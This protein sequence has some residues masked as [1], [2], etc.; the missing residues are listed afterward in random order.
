MRVLFDQPTPVPLRALLK[1]Y[2]VTTAAHQGWGKQ[3]GTASCA[4]TS[5]RH[6]PTK[7][8]NRLLPTA[9]CFFPA[10]RIYSTNRIED[11][12]Q[13]ARLQIRRG[14]RGEFTQS[15]KRGAPPGRGAWA[16]HDPPDSKSLPHADRGRAQGLGQDPDFKFK[17]ADSKWERTG[18]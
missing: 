10:G 11:G 1:G 8:A 9:Y 15:R 14:Y 2:A 17:M 3:E 7:E 5:G 18:Q 12:R 16:C 4:P 6:L 13:V